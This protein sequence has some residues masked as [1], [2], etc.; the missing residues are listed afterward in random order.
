MTKTTRKKHYYPSKRRKARR[1][2]ESYRAKTEAGR[3]KKLENLAKGRGRRA[4]RE[5]AGILATRAK[6]QAKDLEGMDVIDF[7]NDVLGVSF[8]ERPVQEVILRAQYG[9]PLDAEQLEMYDKLTHS[10]RYCPGY[11]RSEGVYVL[12][13]RS[14]KSFLAS[15]VAIYEAV[16]REPRWR[17]FLNVGERAY[18]IITATRLLQSQMVIGASCLRMLENSQIKHFVTDAIACEI[19]LENGISILS[20]PCSSTAG[21]GLAICCLICDELAWY[22]QEGPKQDQEIFRALRPRM[23]QFRGAKFLAIS[24]PASKQGLLYD[25]YEEGIDPERPTPARLTVHGETIFVNPMVDPDFLE[26]EQRRDIDNYDREFLALFC[27]SVDA[28]FPADKLRECFVLGGDVPYDSRYR[29]HCAVDQSGLSGRDRF[30][31]SIAHQEKDKVIVDVSRTWA[32]KAGD[33]IIAEIREITKPYGISSIAVDRYAG[34]WVKLAF[35]R[36]GFEVTVRD[37]LPPIYVNLKSLVISGR[38]SLP[39]TKGLKEGLLRTNASYGKSNQLSIVHERTAEGHGDE[40]DSVATAIWLASSGR[41]NGFFSA[42][43]LS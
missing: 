1:T 41:S 28:F 37:L 22:R 43:D 13:A 23:S 34:G 29:Y 26:S 40:A 12:G 18:V 10:Q 8:A 3:Q 24:T 33:A 14:G 36:Q 9:L 38:V 32:T 2:R 19:L 6:L 31:M 16:I 25:L 30:A 42:E 20:M 7:A 39:D 17:K 4:K 5:K 27:E 11:E 35:E 15:I 21:R